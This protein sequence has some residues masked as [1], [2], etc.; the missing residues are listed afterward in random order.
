MPPSQVP[1]YAATVAR[2]PAVALQAAPHR[3]PGV[4]LV[5]LSPCVHTNTPVGAVPPQIRLTNHTLG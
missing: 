2:A 1:F 4:A 5:R 3:S